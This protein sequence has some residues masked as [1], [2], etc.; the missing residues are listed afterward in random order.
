MA[1]DPAAGAA[2]YADKCA[3]CH[4]PTGRGN[5]PQASQLP[6]P[7]SPLGSSEFANQASLADWYRVVTQGN[8]ER[9]M[10]PFA[11]LTD[12]ERWDVVAYAFSLST[13]AEQ[14]TRGQEIYQANCASCHGIRGEGDGPEASSLS[15]LPKDFTNQEY[16]A[17]KTGMQ[18]FQGITEGIAPDMPAYAEELTDNARWDLVAY[19]RSLTFDTQPLASDTTTTQQVEETAA[20]AT[21]EATPASPQEATVGTISGQVITA[22]TGS[23]LPSD[24]TVTLHGFDQMQQALTDTTEVSSDGSFVFE[25]VEMP[26][27]RAFLTS[28]EHQGVAY[29]SDIGV[30][31]STTTELTLPIPYYDTTTDTGV[32]SVDRLHLLFEYIE[33]NT[34]QV[35]ELYVISNQS[36]RVLVAE[37]V[38]EPV[39][40]FTLPEGATNLQFEDGALG[41]RYIQTDEGFGDT[42]VVRPGSQY[43]VVYSYD[44]PYSRKFAFTHKINLP[45]NAMVILVPATGMRVNGDQLRDMGQS[46]VQGTTYQMYSTDW[47]EAGSNL[48]LEIS[49]RPGGGAGFILSSRSSL[50]AGL[51]ALGVVLLIAGVWLYRRNQASGMAAPGTG[52]PDAELAQEDED[53]DTDFLL[54]AILTLD[55][56]YQ[57]G[58]L[59]EEAYLQR[60]AELKERLKKTVGTKDPES[61]GS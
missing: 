30:V 55:D 1:P 6:N 26:E 5:G 50:V 39:L 37:E 32:I 27:G 33:P 8:L 9:F 54:D 34:L 57:A 21:V 61:G 38:G 53:E 58:E 35:I 18:L 56:Q 24:L 44:L 36:D 60:R 19:L 13:S 48:N 59:P 22:T 46:E 31:E 23:E 4:G 12:R 40:N 10:P 42:A 3:P 29:S 41:A 52:F 45:V 16:I 15:I 47:L 11:S 14:I 49:G 2:I 43:Q 17:A 20:L 51:L 7:P 28:L 25:S